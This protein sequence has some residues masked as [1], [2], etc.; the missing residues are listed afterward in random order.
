M[1][2]IIR[3]LVNFGYSINFFLLEGNGKDKRKDKCIPCMDS[4]Y[5]VV[6]C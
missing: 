3:I 4:E 6:S 5:W 2:W 1:A